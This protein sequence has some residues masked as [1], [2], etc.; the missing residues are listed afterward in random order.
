MELLLKRSWDVHRESNFQEEKTFGL[1]SMKAS[2]GI[3]LQEL[4]KMMAKIQTYL[5]QITHILLKEMLQNKV[6]SSSSSINILDKMLL[7]RKMKLITL[8]LRQSHSLQREREH[9][10]LSSMEME[11]ES[12]A[13]VH[14]ICFLVI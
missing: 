8:S 13:K 14:Q 11:S 1:S 4:R 10:L 2:C 5:F 6:S 12:T 9:Q 7:A 3:A